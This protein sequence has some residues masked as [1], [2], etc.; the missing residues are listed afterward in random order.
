MIAKISCARFAGRALLIATVLALS[1][2]QA[3]AGAKKV[4]KCETISKAGFYQ[5]SQNLV[6]TGG[7]CL[8][9]SA[10]GVVLDLNGFGLTGSGSGTGILITASD[11]FIDANDKTGNGKDITNFAIG[12]EDDGNNAVVENFGA[13]M[14]TDTGLFV[15]GASGSTFG[16]FGTGHN[17]KHGIHL[18]NASHI[19]LHN[20]GPSNNGTYG[21]WVETSS[22]NL[23]DQFFSATNGIA[24]IY[25]GCSA[26]GPAG[27]GCDGFNSASN[28]VASGQMN[29]SPGYG[30]AID[31][32]SLGNVISDAGQ[33]ANSTFDVFDGNTLCGTNL[34][35]EN[36]YSSSNEPTCTN[37]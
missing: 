37:E 7:V 25:I 33:N 29:S 8:T 34:W 4:K 15:N 19:V 3:H 14:N 1:A 35:F 23:I 26:T 36:S 32:A 27:P 13:S 6:S 22:N 5:L 10:P 18:R 12:I 30:L 16:S 17:T 31:E 9:I 21:V 11:V 24:N 28:V 2:G 20:F